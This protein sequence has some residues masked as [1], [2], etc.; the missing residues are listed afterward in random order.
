[1]RSEL[2]LFEE[3]GTVPA[4]P[5]SAASRE[6][7][8]PRRA[9]QLTVVDVA[10]R[11]EDHRRGTRDYIGA[12]RGYARISGA[13]VHH[14]VI[15]GVLERHG[16]GLHELPVGRPPF[17]S[18]QIAPR[19]R[20]L[21]QTLRAINP[22]FVLLHDRQRDSRALF[23]VS[24]Q[25]GARLVAV[26]HDDGEET[27]PLRRGLHPAFH[28]AR[29]ATRRRHVLY[30]GGLYRDKGIERLLDATALASSEWSLRIA[31]A[32]PQQEA[33][34][35]HARK[36]ALGRQ[37]VFVP[38]VRDRERLARMYAEASCVV[39]PGACE[40]FGL[41]ALEAAASGTPV[42]C[43]ENAPVVAALGDL[44]ET[45]AP[46][47]VPALAAAIIRARSRPADRFA[48]ARIAADHSWEQVLEAELDDLEALAR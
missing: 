33:L 20:G 10:L 41:V 16:A 26:G 4:R 18:T 6:R 23:R 24:E 19:A 2:T 13:F 7:R 3:A 45:F 12:K 28:P 40:T 21:E 29:N 46:G 27:I 9:R 42:V 22:D 30:V 14:A 15:P 36:L 37:V 1:M 32:G 31:G 38:Y 11:D 34:R 8:T 17:G 47:D 44:A 25:V 39:L 43:S 5:R 35:R 48:A